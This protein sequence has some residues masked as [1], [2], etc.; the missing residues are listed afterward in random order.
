V[1]Q[2]AAAAANQSEG[3]VDC[4]APIGAGLCPI[5]PLP[6]SIS[7]V[8]AALGEGCSD[9]L[10]AFVEREARREYTEAS[11]AFE[12][13]VASVA[14]DNSGVMHAVNGLLARVVA[15]VRAVAARKHEEGG[16]DTEAEA[17]VEEFMAKTFSTSGRGGGFGA[18]GSDPEAVRDL[19]ADSSEERLREKTGVVNQEALLLAALEATD[20]REEGWGVAGGEEEALARQLGIDFAF[21]CER[22]ALTPLVDGLWGKW[23]VKQEGWTARQ[24]EFRTLASE[25]SQERATR[26]HEGTL[27]ALD[28]G[29]SPAESTFAARL[30][31]AAPAAAA[32][33]DAMPWFS[34]D[35]RWDIVDGCELACA[36]A[37]AGLPLR[38]SSSGTTFQILTI[39]RYLGVPAE[40]MPLLRLAAVAFL[41]PQHHS[42]LEVMLGA[43][44]Y[45]GAGPLAAGAD[46]WQHL[47]PRDYCFQ[48]PGGGGAVTRDSLNAEIEAE[49]RGV[50]DIS[51]AGALSDYAQLL[52]KYRSAWPVQRLS[53]DNLRKI[54]ARFQ[55]C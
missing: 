26:V 10:A 49:M 4:W 37:A 8:R 55:P 35:V 43:S 54:A 22:R 21:F 44:E 14:Y 52:G 41:C 32:D 42:F 40:E 7:A 3:E 47:L 38:A 36:A 45:C 9:E 27:A 29:L 15:F 2:H 34:G 51:A 48:L 25:A 30:R 6:L 19:L 11:T 13:V 5:L 23:F 31:A 18:F 1:Q 16:G 46:C 12:L 50:G 20:A 28:M 53:P 39:A 17:F 24:L 33:A